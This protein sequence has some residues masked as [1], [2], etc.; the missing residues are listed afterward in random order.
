MSLYMINARNFVHGGIKTKFV[1][2]F[3]GD[4]NDP[5]YSCWNFMKI[6]RENMLQIE[7]KMVKIH[8]ALYMQIFICN[9]AVNKLLFNASTN[10]ISIIYHI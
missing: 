8:I 6:S 4:E 10:T 7:G 1:C 3:I 2:C 9:K 5:T